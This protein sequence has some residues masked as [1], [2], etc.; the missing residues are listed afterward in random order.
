[1]R[2]VCG[3]ITL[4]PP[5]ERLDHRE[6]DRPGRRAAGNHR[7]DLVRRHHRGHEEHRREGSLRGTARD[8]G[9]ALRP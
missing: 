5:E 9:G 6:Q 1:M 8:V 3:I 2:S 7:E 4:T